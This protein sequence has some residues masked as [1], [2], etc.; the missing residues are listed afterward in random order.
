MSVT[1]AAHDRGS[2]DIITSLNVCEGVSTLIEYYFE[3]ST[4]LLT[5]GSLRLFACPFDWMFSNYFVLADII[6]SNFKKC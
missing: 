1:N 4:N 6:S 2:Q 5:A 3:G